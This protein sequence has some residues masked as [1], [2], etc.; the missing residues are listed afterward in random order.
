MRV[1]YRRRMPVI[2]RIAGNIRGISLSRRT[3][4]ARPSRFTVP[5][6]S[7]GFFLPQKCAAGFVRPAVRRSSGTQ[8]RGTGSVSQ[9]AR[10]IRR[11]TRNWG[12]MSGWRRRGITTT[13]LT[14]YRR[15]TERS[16]VGSQRS[17]RGEDACPAR[18][19]CAVIYAAPLLLECAPKWS[20][21][22]RCKGADLRE[23]RAIRA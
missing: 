22:D 1:R 5:S 15:G 11:R 6:I 18:W 23:Q 21:R 3:F 2:A 4:P 17:E 14:G 20:A 19:R 13:S 10:L 16:E 12:S 9:W 7:A 8:S